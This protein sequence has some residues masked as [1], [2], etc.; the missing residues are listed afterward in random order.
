VDLSVSSDTDRAARTAQNESLF[1]EVNERVKELNT[2]F[3]ALARH[4][5]WIC[6][7]G[8]T[9]CLEPVQMTQ[10]EYESVRARGSD[11]FLVKPGEAHVVPEVDRVVER[12]DRYWVV[13]KLGVAAEVADDEAAGG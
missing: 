12:S 9:D 2:T 3:D 13:Q 4:A 10:E 1:R 5:E 6:E 11:Y 8:N 7:C